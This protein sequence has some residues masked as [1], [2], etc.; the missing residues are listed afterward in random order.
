MRLTKSLDIALMALIQ[1]AASKKQSSAAELA[2]TLG[3]PR[4]HVA[5]IMQLL[6]R[7]GYVRTLQGKGGGIRLV[8][9]PQ[10]I[11]L[12]EIIDLV[13]GP[14]YLMECTVEPGV[15]PLSRGC[16]LA[17]KFKEA[18][19]S[20]MSVFRRTTLADVLPRKSKPGSHQAGYIK[21]ERG[22]AR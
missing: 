16:R 14:V 17:Q 13:E 21:D 12:K 2:Q 15:C 22:G 10:A 18:Q 11:V 20:M 5:K 4:N 19:E 7:G 9:P 3:A 1:L 6:G 8:K